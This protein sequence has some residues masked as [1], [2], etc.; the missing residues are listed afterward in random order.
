[1]I[2]YN[3]VIALLCVIQVALV[4]V[5]EFMK[6]EPTKAIMIKN[7]EKD[8]QDF[9]YKYLQNNYHL[10]LAN[11]NDLESIDRAMLQIKAEPDFYSK[12]PD[13]DIM[14]T[15]ILLNFLRNYDLYQKRIFHLIW[16]IVFVIVSIKFGMILI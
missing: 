2:N 10:E 16:F 8:L 7:I 13:E 9:H 3:I 15:N 12:I 11:L 4:I 14:A 1:M 6:Y 5:Y